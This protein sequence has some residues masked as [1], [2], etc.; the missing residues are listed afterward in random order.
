MPFALPTPALSF[1][2]PFNCKGIPLLFPIHCKRL[3]LLLVLK[4]RICKSFKK[5][6]KS[7]VIVVTGG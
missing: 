4:A 5:H 6:T 3:P 2:F 7:F 1:A